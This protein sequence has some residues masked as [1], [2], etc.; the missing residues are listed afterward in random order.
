V[1]WALALSLA[2]WPARAQGTDQRAILSLSVN[3]VQHGEVVVIVRPADVLVEPGVLDRAGLAGCAGRRETVGGREYVSLASLAPGIAYA[4]DE[5]ALSLA[6]TAAPVHLGSVV[7]NLAVPRP[8]YEFARATSGFLNYGVNWTETSGTDASIEAGVSIGAAI[9]Q[10]TMS[11]DERRGFVRGLSNLIVDQP[12]RLRRWTVGDSLVPAEGLGSGMLVGGV[13][14]ARD[15]GLDPYF[16]QFPTL[17][18]SGTTLTPSTVDVYVNGNLVSRQTVAPGTFTLDHVPMPNGSNETRVVVRD[19][20]GREQQMAAPFY[21]TTSGLARG[22]HDYDYAVGFPRLGGAETNWSYGS[23]AAVARH[24]YGFSD[25]L[26]A[27]FSAEADGDGLA[28]GPTMNLRLP[29]ADLE[30]AASFSRMGGRGGA[31]VLAA[32]SHTGRVF[33]VGA[34][35][36]SMSPG[37]TT[38]MVREPDERVRLELAGQ[39]GVQLFARAS[40]SFQQAV[41]ATYGGPRRSET[42]IVGTLRLTRLLNLFVNGSRSAE[43][44]AARTSVYTGVSMA[45]GS[46]T[47][48]SVW[49]Q[50]GAVGRGASAEVQRSLPVGNGVG[51]RARAA[52]GGSTQAEGTFEAQGPYGHYEASQGMIDGRS[53]TRVSTAGG[54]AFIGGGAHPTRPVNDSFALVRVPDV[55]GVRTYLNNHEVGRTDRRGN[56]LVPNLL[57]YYANRIAI[58]DQDVPIDH[59]IETVE[60]SIAPPYRGGALVTFR[61]TRHQGVTGTVSIA[62]GGQ[63]VLPALGE[64]TITV[65]ARAYSSPIGAAGEFYFE[66]LPAGQ[67]AAVV[68][69]KG[70]TCRVTLTVPASTEPVIRLGVVRCGGPVE[71]L[72]RRP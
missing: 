68:V 71:P 38:L 49:T 10:N 34:R 33:T 22:L 44:G 8:E 23:L 12:G 7:L 17:G 53:S 61:T 54:L 30:L 31:A 13:R 5:A 67:H 60:Q 39:A 45:L 72:E 32:A 4:V 57:P 28:G 58:S 40:V 63:T 70:G 48:A 29:H 3:K 21:M 20:F 35:A 9:A 41:A 50:A 69:F 64:V 36:R 18:L 62:V 51:Y 6:I 55:G 52:L 65:G 43:N 1:S 47:T 19:A 42:S 26:T 11:W 16:V 25:D 46:A 2:P 27:G 15:Y 14:V 37:Y 24:R 66:N 59:E 56:A